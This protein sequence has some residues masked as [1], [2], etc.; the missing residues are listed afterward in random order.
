MLPSINANNRDMGAIDNVLVRLSNDIESTSLLVLN[1]P[2]PAGALD[3]SKLAVDVANEL[4]KRAIVLS[5]SLAE[6]RVSSRGLTA[7][8]GRR[9]KVLPEERVVDVATAVES[10]SRGQVDL[11]SN[12]A[13]SL[14]LSELLNGSIVTIDVGLVVLGVVELKKKQ[15]KTQY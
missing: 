1:N 7:T 8:L 3:T 15:K 4:V 11:S 10:D 6:L 5:N 13:G 2:G 12:I 14:G 9:G